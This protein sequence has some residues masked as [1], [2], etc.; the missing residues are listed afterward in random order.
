MSVKNGGKSPSVG[1]IFILFILKIV[2]GL[3]KLFHVKGTCSSISDE[4][5]KVFSTILDGMKQDL[6]KKDG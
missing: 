3:S 6:D 5:Q 2:G 1:S 4:E